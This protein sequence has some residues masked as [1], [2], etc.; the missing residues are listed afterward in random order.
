MYDAD[1]S[2]AKEKKKK[3]TFPFMSLP[4]E[5]RNKIYGYLLV[6]PEE[7]SLIEGPRKKGVAHGMIEDSRKIYAKQ[8]LFDKFHPAVLRVR[9]KV[10]QEAAPILYGQK[11]H[12]KRFHDFEEF[13]TE[14]GP[15]NRLLL[16]DLSIGIWFAQKSTYMDMKYTA[17]ILLGTGTDRARV[18]FTHKKGR[19][20]WFELDE[21]SGRS[22][23][24]FQYVKHFLWAIDFVKGKRA[25]L[26]V[27][28][29]GGALISSDLAHKDEVDRREEVFHDRV[30]DL[31]YS[32]HY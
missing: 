25:R 27:L 3:T 7:L 32:F 17:T 18:N 20:S 16:R 13:L 21:D 29:M 24:L 14:I 1:T 19:G 9:R 30:R 2:Q 31:K 11:L 4:P 23:C 10:F 15:T 6:A 5:L 22:D 28:Q 8:P 12:F 26:G